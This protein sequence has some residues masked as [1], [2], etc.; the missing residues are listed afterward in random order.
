MGKSSKKKDGFSSDFLRDAVADAKTV[1]ETALENA[2]IALQEAFTP[3]L[4]SMLTD[5]LQQEVD[6]EV[7]VDEELKSSEIGTADN[8]EP[9]KTANDTST[10]DAEGPHG[11]GA[12]DEDE[13]FVPSKYGVEEAIDNDGD[14]IDEVYEDE[15][16]DEMDYEE[17][18]DEEGD[19]EEVDD[20]MDY[21][22]EDDLDL[23]SILKELEDGVELEEDQHDDLERI[24]RR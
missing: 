2:K 14:V 23:E 6:E 12:A 10:V 15:E 9:T 18:D 11:D 17:S 19:D 21:E 5:K 20:E 1:R 3:K 22:E 24:D 8:K 7:T 16:G 13:D 4:Q